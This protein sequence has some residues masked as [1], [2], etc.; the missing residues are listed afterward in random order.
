MWKNTLA[1]NL[2]LPAQEITLSSI[3]TNQEAGL[4]SHL[5]EVKLLSRVTIQDSKQQPPT[6]NGPKWPRLD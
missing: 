6:T 4:Q 5:Q 3:I 2:Q 1:L